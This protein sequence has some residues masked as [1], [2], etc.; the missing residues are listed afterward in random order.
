MLILRIRFNFALFSFLFEKV[1]EDWML[2]NV[3]GIEKSICGGIWKV[4]HDRLN[5]CLGPDDILNQLSLLVVDF[6][7]WCF[8]LITSFIDFTLDMLSKFLIPNSWTKSNFGQLFPTNVW[9]R[10]YMVSTCEIFI[11]VSVSKLFGIPVSFSCMIY[12]ICHKLIDLFFRWQCFH[13]IHVLDL[14][15]NAEI[16][17]NGKIVLL[18]ELVEHVRYILELSL[19]VFAV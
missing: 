18:I 14:L 15:I 5:G 16:L 11:G 2:R 13:N 17:I 12:A 3:L 6:I 1:T 4:L 19:E 7:E 8:E 10:N 9:M